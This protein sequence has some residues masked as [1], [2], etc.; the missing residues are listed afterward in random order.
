[1]CFM[2]VTAARVVPLA[3]KSSQALVW[4][5][6]NP[7]RE[8]TPLHDSTSRREKLVYLIFFDVIDRIYS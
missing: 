8:S 2:S 3:F 5:N 6:V 1:M 7:I 4:L